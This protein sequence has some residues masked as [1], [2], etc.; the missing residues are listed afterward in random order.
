MNK[1]N[2]HKLKAVIFTGLNITLWLLAGSLWVEGSVERIVPV[3]LAAMFVNYMSVTSIETFYRA[4]LIGTM[5]NY[6]I[7]TVGLKE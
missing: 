5:E 7:D 1:L 4:K 6:G 2:Q 3:L